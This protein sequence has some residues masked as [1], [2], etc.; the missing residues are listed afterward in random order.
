MIHVIKNILN[1]VI[2]HQIRNLLLLLFVLL[3]YV[4]SYLRLYHVGLRL[5]HVKSTSSCPI[6]EV[7]QY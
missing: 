6:I 4:I 7:K 2:V 1:Y 3:Y 5:Y